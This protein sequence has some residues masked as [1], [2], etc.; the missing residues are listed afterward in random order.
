MKWNKYKY[1]ELSFIHST[2]VEFCVQHF[3][4]FHHYFSQKW[5]LLFR[6]RM[7]FHSLPFHSASSI[8][9]TLKN[10]HF[11]HRNKHSRYLWHVVIRNIVNGVSFLSYCGWSLCIFYRFHYCSQLSAT[12]H[13]CTFFLSLSIQ[14]KNCKWREGNFS[15]N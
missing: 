9:Y 15:L 6:K 10:S 14:Q 11:L 1:Q 7:I 4:L 8:F 12:N 3:S 5:N 13:I 2:R